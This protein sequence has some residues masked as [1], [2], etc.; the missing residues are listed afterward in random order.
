MLR[1]VGVLGWW[2]LLGSGGN[3]GGAAPGCVWWGRGDTVLLPAS[4]G[5]TPTE[6]QLGL[7]GEEEKALDQKIQIW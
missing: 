7:G 5:P 2:L 6:L 3:V 4:L 1:A